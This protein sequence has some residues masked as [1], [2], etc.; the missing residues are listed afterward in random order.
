MTY[1][2]ILIILIYL[3]NSSGK[4]RDIL[5]G[6]I[7]YRSD[8]QDSG[9]G[10]CNAQGSLPEECVEHDGFYRR[11]HR[12]CGNGEVYILEIKDCTEIFNV[13]LFKECD[14]SGV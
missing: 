14:L 1:H 2:F 13:N 5:F 9:I 7:L 3:I 8:V 11:C 6:H 10:L 12:V 4:D